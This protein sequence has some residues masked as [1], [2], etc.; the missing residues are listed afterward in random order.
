MELEI[1]I[2]PY[3]MYQGHCLQCG[4]TTKYRWSLAKIIKEGLKHKCSR[5]LFR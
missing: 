2:R 5:F 1:I 3:F 4:H